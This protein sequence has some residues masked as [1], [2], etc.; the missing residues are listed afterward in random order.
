MNKRE[1]TED[2]QEEEKEKLRKVE[3]KQWIKGKKIR[4]LTRKRGRKKEEE[5]K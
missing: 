4:R 2:K 5:R 3:I 1:E